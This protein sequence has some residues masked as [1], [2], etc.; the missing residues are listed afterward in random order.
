MDNYP[1]MTKDRHANIITFT[2]GSLRVDALNRQTIKELRVIADREGTTIEQVM[3]DALDW[4][5]RTPEEFR[6]NS[7]NE[8]Y[9]HHKGIDKIGTI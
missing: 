5:L 4:V 1:P 6:T 9:A 7:N 2:W 3:S 8:E